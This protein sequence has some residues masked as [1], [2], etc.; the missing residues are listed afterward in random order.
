VPFLVNRNGKATSSWRRKGDIP[1][2]W[3]HG[4]V[5]SQD[6]VESGVKIGPG[7]EDRL[8]MSESNAPPINGSSRATLPS[9]RSSL[10]LEDNGVHMMRCKVLPRRGGSRRV[11]AV[12]MVCRR[13][14]ERTGPAVITCCRARRKPRRAETG[15][16]SCER[17]ENRERADVHS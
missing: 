8:E 1:W 3:P 17:E 12:D 2:G 4:Q 11:D 15:A 9:Q 10:F 13:C 16:E 14:V 6:V 7:E 5:G